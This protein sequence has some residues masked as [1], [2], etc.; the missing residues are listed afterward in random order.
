MV[1]IKPKV[2]RDTCRKKDESE[3]NRKHVKDFL[4]TLPNMPSH[5]C[6]ANSTKRYLEPFIQNKNALYKLH[7]VWWNNKK[8]AS[9]WLLHCVFK[10]INFF[11]AKKISATFAAH[12]N[13]EIYPRKPINRTYLRRI[14]PELNK[15]WTKKL[16]WLMG[17]QWY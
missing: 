11:L 7:Q 4:G 8:V 17:K 3:E 12:M 6:R 14:W 15:L 1:F 9:K 16:H 10:E 13:H 5:S 2:K